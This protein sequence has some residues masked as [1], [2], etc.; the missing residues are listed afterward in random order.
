MQSA[1]PPL[2]ESECDVW[3]DK[4]LA[5]A[6]RAHNETV[7]PRYRPTPEQMDKIRARMGPELKKACLQLDRATYECEIRANDRESLT[8]CSDKKPQP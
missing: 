2:S 7:D 3:I 4:F 8:A 5:M 6:L 1:A